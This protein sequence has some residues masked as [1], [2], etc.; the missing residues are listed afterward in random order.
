MNQTQSQHN[1]DRAEQFWILLFV[2]LTMISM[3][4]MDGKMIVSRDVF[5]LVLLLTGVVAYFKDYWLLMTSC[6]GL[7]GMIAMIEYL[8]L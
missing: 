2:S 7:A 1:T 8:L 3:L 5:C 4:D 6:M